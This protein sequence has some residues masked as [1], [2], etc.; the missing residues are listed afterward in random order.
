MLIFYFCQEEI[1]MKI[2][3][4]ILGCFLIIVGIVPLIKMGLENELFES[5]QL[6]TPLLAVSAGVSIL[7]NF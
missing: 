1:D 4:R 3:M 5:K 6:I 2:I 7:K